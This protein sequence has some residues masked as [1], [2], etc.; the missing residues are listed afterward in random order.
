MSPAARAS[1][2]GRRLDLVVI[3][4]ASAIV[5]SQVGFLGVSAGS[6]LIQ[7]LPTLM[8]RHDGCASDT[9]VAVDSQHHLVCLPRSTKVPPGWTVVRLPSTR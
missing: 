9:T 2:W 7:S 4:G 6:A 8:G 1:R 5:A 3:A